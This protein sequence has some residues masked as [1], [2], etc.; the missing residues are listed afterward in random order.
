M[1]LMRKLSNIFTVKMVS[2]L[3]DSDICAIYGEVQDGTDADWH[4]LHK[5]HEGLNKAIRGVEKLLAS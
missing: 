2:A 5:Q 3:S 1:N 4:K